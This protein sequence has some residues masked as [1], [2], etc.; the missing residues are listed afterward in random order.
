MKKNSHRMLSLIFAI[1]FTM[2]FSMPA[3]ALEDVSIPQLEAELECVETFEHDHDLH[4]ITNE[5][6]IQSLAYCYHV[7][8]TSTT[9]SLNYVMVGTLRHAHQTYTNVCIYCGEYYYSTQCHTT[10]NCSAI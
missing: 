8:K 3:F 6:N 4:K 9:G 2:V 1:I 5:E 7:Y 10:N